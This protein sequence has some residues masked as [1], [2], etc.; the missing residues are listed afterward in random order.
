VRSG[1][2]RAGATCCAE[3]S[4]GTEQQG[5]MKQHGG[6]PKLSPQRCVTQSV[7]RDMNQQSEL[8][9]RS[10]AHCRPPGHRAP[11]GSALGAAGA[12]TATL[13]APD[14]RERNEARDLQQQS[15][16]ELGPCATPRARLGI[17]RSSRME[18][19]CS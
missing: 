2:E 14:C 18:R 8:K 19:R 1:A 3:R 17:E 13:R 12:A 10:Y 15:K 9:Q 16:Q 6:T 4:Q 11:H 7:A 5:H